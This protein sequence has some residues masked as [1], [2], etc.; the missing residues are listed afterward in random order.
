MRSGTRCVAPSPRRPKLDSSSVPYLLEEKHL[1][2]K[3]KTGV[4]EYI[5]DPAAGERRRR[6]DAEEMAARAPQAVRDARS[7][8]RDIVPKGC[9]M[10]GISGAAR[11]W[12]SRRSP[13]CFQLPL[14]RIDMIEVFS[15]RHGNP[16][17]TFVSACRTHGGDGAGGDVVRRDRDGRHGQGPT[18]PPVAWGAS[19][20]SSSPGCRRRRAACSSL[21]LPTA[22][23][24]CRRR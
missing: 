20:P 18:T 10:M 8:E 21:P 15:G 6:A 5:A 19:S 9:C 22:S 17:G 2:V 1:L 11:A 4:I 12:P 16:E 14:Y 3:K 13:Q 7:A 23:T 24:C